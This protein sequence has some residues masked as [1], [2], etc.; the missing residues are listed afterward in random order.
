MTSPE[1]VVRVG[2]T[3]RR[4]RQAGSDLLE[5]LLTHL[6]RVGFDGAPRFLGID[7]RGRQALS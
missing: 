4:P 2:N 1:G 6:E 3:V 5:A 7:A